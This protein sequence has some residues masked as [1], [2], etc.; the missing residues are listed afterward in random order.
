MRQQGKR[1]YSSPTAL[2]LNA[3][4]SSKR[5]QNDE[6]SPLTFIDHSTPIPKHPRLKAL[7]LT[8]VE[9]K[10]I[11]AKHARTAKEVLDTKERV[12]SKSRVE[13][14]LGSIAAA[15]YETLYAF[16]DELLNTRDQ[17]ISS[18]VSKMLGQH[19]EAILNNIRARQPDLATQWAVN[20]SGQIL[21]EEGQRLANYLRP[22]ADRGMSDVL[23]KFSLEKIMADAEHI[24]PTLCNLLRQIA[25]NSKPNARDNVR[26]DRSL[27]CIFPSYLTISDW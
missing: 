10:N 25:T 2:A 21:A 6:N 13:H 12:D 4:V 20:V 16:V 22:A 7:P 24:A 26:K 9:I 5:G 3:M 1:A 27:V 18:R 11:Q 17:Q 19:S 14:V 23:Q 8:P 15:G